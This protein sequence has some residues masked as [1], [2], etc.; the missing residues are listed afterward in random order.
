[1]G[2]LRSPLA[3]VAGASKV[4]DPANGRKAAREAWMESGIVLINPAWLVKC[5]DRAALN[6]LAI[7][8]HGE[9]RVA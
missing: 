8:V 4:I 6:A 9:R 2:N 7:M 5:E 1:M 3:S